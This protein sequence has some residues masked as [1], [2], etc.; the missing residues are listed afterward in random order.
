MRCPTLSPPPPPTRPRQSCWRCALWLCGSSVL[1]GGAALALTNPNLQQYGQF[2]ADTSQR[3]VQRE[4]CARLEA[5][6]L[7]KMERLCDRLG[8]QASE[9]FKQWVLKSSQRHNYG[10]LSIYE[11]RLS[12]RTLLQ[13]TELPDWRLEFKCIGAL[14][15]FN[16]VQVDWKTEA[17]VKD[18]PDSQGKLEQQP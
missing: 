3:L 1:L 7:T 8:Q 6:N 10:L 13:S 2:S 18:D 17:A 14:S 9:E 5:L 4:V 11:T 15:G 12:L 16:V